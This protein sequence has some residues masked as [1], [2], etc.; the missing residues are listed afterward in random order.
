MT[1]RD[2]VEERLR[3]ARLP[4][5]A[6]SLRDRVLAAACPRVQPR[7]A[8]GDRVWFSRGWRLAAVA[9]LFAT[10]ALDRIS[11]VPGPTDGA[12]GPVA[13]QTARAAREAARQAGLRPDQADALARRVLVAAS[14]PVP[15]SELA[16]DDF[17]TEH[18]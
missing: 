10:V 3:A 1:R 12:P 18:R 5:Q 15:G 9:V 13:V 4:A 2:S 6:A 16:L 7:V 8:W 11:S 17:I 14:R